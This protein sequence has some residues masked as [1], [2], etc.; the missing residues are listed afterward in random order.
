MHSARHVP[1]LVLDPEHHLKRAALVVVGVQFQTTKG[2]FHSRLHVAHV[3]DKVASLNT[4]VQHVADQEL[5]IAR[6]K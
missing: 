5:N 1:A 2:S 6:A 4:R 3:A